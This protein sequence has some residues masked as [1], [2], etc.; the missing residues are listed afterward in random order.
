M[1]ASFSPT[2]AHLERWRTLLHDS[3]EVSADACGPAERAHASG[4]GLYRW[5]PEYS[6]DVDVYENLI[7]RHL[8]HSA[9]KDCLRTFDNAGN[10]AAYTYGQVDSLVRL[11][12]A[13]VDLPPP[14]ETRD[15]RR[16]VGRD[17]CSDAGIGVSRLSP[18]RGDPHAAAG[19][20]RCQA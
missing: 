12:A 2:E 15:H 14:R 17:G 4:P 19:F 11:V 13:R 16:P 3:L 5:F 9:D 8:P 1:N 18:H 6:I 10:Y 20:G 7:T